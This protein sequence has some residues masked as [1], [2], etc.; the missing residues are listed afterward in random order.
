MHSVVE[1][2]WPVPIECTVREGAL[3]LRGGVHVEFGRGTE[4]WSSGLRHRLAWL[5]GHAGDGNAVRLGF[6]HDASLAPEEFV[7]DID[8]GI[9]IR[10]G[11]ELGAGH[12]TVTLRQL[13]PADAYRA[14]PLDREQWSLPLVRIHDAPAFAWRGFMLD[15]ARHF[16]PKDELLRVIER[17]AM[18]RLNRLHLHL[19]DDQGW[20]IESPTYPQIAAV[21]TWR[22][23]SGIGMIPFDGST[24]Q[25]D[26]TPHGGFYTLDDLREITAYARMHCITIVPEIDLPAHASALLAAV[27]EARV[28]G[29][30]VPD[31][32]TTFLPSGRVV[33][34][35]PEGRAVLATLLAELASA[36]DSPYLHIGGDE[37]SLADWQGSEAVLAYT[38]HQGLADVEA[39]R[40]DLNAFLVGVVEALGR[41]AVVWEEAFIGGGLSPSTIV[42]AWRAEQAGLAA[43]AHGHDVVMLPIAGNYLDYAE[44]GDGEPLALG[45][46]QGVERVAAY[47]P[48]RGDGP[49]R[50]LGVQAALWTEF[51]PDA[52]LRSYK[53]FPRLAVH[54]ANA[55][56]GSTTAWPEQRGALE[57]HLQR[58]DAAGVEYRPLDGPHPWQRGGHG[59]RQ[60]TS[61]LTI[62]MIVAMAAGVA[63]GSGAP[64]LEELARVMQDGGEAS[65]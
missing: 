28:P 47:T 3:P 9:T 53:M 2:L 42:M 25:V 37:A 5:L 54:S 19:T 4:A 32:A 56:T 8:S 7:L 30:P 57:L 17:M 16:A 1:R 48:T 36:V 63:A 43:L 26:D 6:E 49:G 10:A 14:M 35:L 39:L 34:P 31:V 22:E 50:M 23:A 15:V 44:G 58:L 59:R 64:D 24:Q 51:V 20:R 60:H 61:P 33:N 40:A 46:G 18:H 29:A 45:S 52:R 55:W 21:A 12:A 38:Q 41:R 65:A 62:D 11:S 27:P 13:L